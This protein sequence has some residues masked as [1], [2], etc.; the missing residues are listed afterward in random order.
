MSC[1]YFRN[2]K[3]S[4]LKQTFLV[5]IPLRVNWQNFPLFAYI[6]T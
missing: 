2:K 1:I 6:V 3:P 4:Y 5:H